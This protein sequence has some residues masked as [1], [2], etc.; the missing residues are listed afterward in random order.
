[1]LA[2]VIPVSR[3]TPRR[4]RLPRGRAAADPLLAVPGVGPSIAADLRSIGIGTI[5]DLATRDPERLYQQLVDNAGTHID[6]CVLYV[7]RCA[8]YYAA[9]PYPNPELLKWWNWKDSAN[10]GGR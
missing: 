4:R 3:S 1:M 7:L 10:A 8:V 2:T 9:E 6:H 5:D